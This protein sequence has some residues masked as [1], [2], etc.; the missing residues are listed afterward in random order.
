MR[1]HGE[2]VQCPSGH[3]SFNLWVLSQQ[4]NQQ[5]RKKITSSST[6]SEGGDYGVVFNI[7]TA[8]TVK[9]I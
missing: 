9:H 5:K 1:C 2:R 4:I 6:L 3:E 8:C 7:A